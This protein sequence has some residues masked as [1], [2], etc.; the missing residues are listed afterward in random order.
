MRILVGG[1]GGTHMKVLVTGHK[2]PVRIPSSPNMT[3]SEMVAAVRAATVTWKYSAVSIGYPESVSSA[4][5]SW[6]RTIL[7][8]AGWVELRRVEASAGPLSRRPN[9]LSWFRH[10]TWTPLIFENVWE[11]MELVHLPYKKSRSYEDSVGAAALK[12]QGKESWRHRVNKVVQQLKAAL[13]PD[14]V[15]LGGG[16]ARLRKKLPLGTRLGNN[17]NAFESGYRLWTKAYSGS[18]HARFVYEENTK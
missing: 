3:V 10:R 14:Y 6:N 2:K 7:G 11:P 5:P 15:V 8:M 16:T 18:T 4:I 13:E 17:A 1:V 12:R 9:A